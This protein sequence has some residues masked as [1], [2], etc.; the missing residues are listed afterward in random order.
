MPYPCN[1]IDNPLATHAGW[2]LIAEYDDS[3][4]RCRVDYRAVH[5]DGRRVDLDVSGY[6][7]GLTAERFA[8]LVALNF[9]R[10][11]VI[12]SR[13]PLRGADI[14]TLYDRAF[15]EVAA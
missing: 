15:N 7:A 13:T 5:E 10:R 9:P 3:P 6:D 4:D 2:A 12:G 8:K 14:D 1:W 11:S